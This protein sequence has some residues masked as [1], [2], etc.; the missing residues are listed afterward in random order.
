MVA[1]LLL[2]GFLGASVA[3]LARA[4]GD[5]GPVYDGR[6]TVNPF[7]H[8]EALGLLVPLFFRFGWTK[9]VAVD[10]KEL[11]GGTGGLVLVA[12]GSIALLLALAVLLWSSRNYLLDR[13][14]NS[15]LVVSLIG[16]IEVAV[17]LALHFAVLNLIPLPPLTAGIIL[18]GLLPA[19]HRWMAERP[20]VPSLAIA[21]FVALGGAQVVLGPVVRALRAVLLV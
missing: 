5:R 15:S 16:W 2:I 1:A 21:A 13:F 10:P 19:A 8:I 18:A 6:A 14:P 17:D 9:P 11:K 20:L 12:L 7:A 3:L 4:L